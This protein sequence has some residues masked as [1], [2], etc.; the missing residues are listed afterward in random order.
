M[1]DN[2]QAIQ[3]PEHETIGQ[4]GISHRTWVVCVVVGIAWIV[5]AGVLLL[6]M[7][8]YLEVKHRVQAPLRGAS[9]AGARLVSAPLTGRDLSRANL[10]AA[11]L[12]GAVLHRAN[13]AGANLTGATLDDADLRSAS[14]RGANLR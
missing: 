5:G 8:P 14:L 2:V 9:L 12:T 3:Q 6:S 4:A 13:L 10:Q 1:Q 11:N 7:R